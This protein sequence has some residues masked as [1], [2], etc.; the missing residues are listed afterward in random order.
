VRQLLGVAA[1][2]D[3]DGADVARLVGGSRRLDHRV[4]HDAA[5][6]DEADERAEVRRGE[7]EQDVDRP[8]EDRGDLGGGVVD[9]LVG[10]R[11]DQPVP[12]AGAG[13]GDDV[14]TGML[15]ELHGVAADRSAGA[16]DQHTLPRGQLR[17]VEQ[18]L[19]G[20][21]THHRQRGGVGELDGRRCPRQDL[22]GRDDVLRGGA[23]GEHRQEPD[24]LVADLEPLHSLAERVADAIVHSRSGLTYQAGLLEKAGLV[25]RTPSPDDERGVTFTITDA[26]RALIAE[27]LP[28]HE[29]VV[30]RML[31]EPLSR[32]DARTLI[33]LLEPVRDHMRSVPRA[34]RRPASTVGGRSPREHFRVS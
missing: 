27:V 2:E 23:V 28:G 19:P 12:A 3:V 1:H 7:V 17:V 8:V 31:F 30:G 24:D 5:V 13:G 4:H 6:A 34:R 10:A 33:G 18:R 21:E 22:G 32:E 20:G 11:R 9:D 16:V 26:G 29:E 14:G 15:R 25:A